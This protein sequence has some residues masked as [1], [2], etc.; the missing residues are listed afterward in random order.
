[1]ELLV[2]SGIW[3]RLSSRSGRWRYLHRAIDREGN[4]LD[5]MLSEHTDK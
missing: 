5:S 2:F 1:M 4:L 3:T